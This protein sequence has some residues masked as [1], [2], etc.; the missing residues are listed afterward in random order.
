MLSQS[1]LS[2]CLLMS[3]CFVLC[4]LVLLPVTFQHFC[5]VCCFV[6]VCFLFG[7]T[8]DADAKQVRQLQSHAAKHTASLQQRIHHLE[9]QLQSTT[10][11]LKQSSAN[12]LSTKQQLQR[13]TTE[14]NIAQRRRTL[15]SLPSSSNDTSSDARDPTQNSYQDLALDARVKQLANEARM[16]GMIRS[17]QKR[18][19]SMMGDQKVGRCGALCLY[20]VVVF[21]DVDNRPLY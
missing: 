11:E 17:L 14:N 12:L 8:Q 10:S 15:F 19:Q 9:E 2:P 5:F 6:F 1:S 16:N 21:T 3:P 7:Q 20:F 4:V 18:L 13:L